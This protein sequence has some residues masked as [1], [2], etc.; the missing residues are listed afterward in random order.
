MP[1][2]KPFAYGTLL[3]VRE[4]QEELKAGALSATRRQ[5]RQAEFQH[6]DLV[7]QQMFMLTEA[8]RR[9]QY[10]FD[11]GDVRRYYQFERYLARLVVEK[12]AQIGEIRRAE[13]VQRAELEEA[14]KKRRIVERL[15]ERWLRARTYTI[16]KNE[17]A[18]L[19]EVASNQAAVSRGPRSQS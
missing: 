2:L 5:L 4:R 3:R 12:H 19:D 10:T 15:K 6:A 17:Q 16:N 13:S 1:S 14:M 11:A 9:T 18:I 7:R 8:G